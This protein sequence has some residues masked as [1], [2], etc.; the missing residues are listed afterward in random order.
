[1]QHRNFC[2]TSSTRSVHRGT[3]VTVQLSLAEVQVAVADYLRKRG[4]IVDDADQVQ[5]LIVSAVGTRMSITGATPVVEV[6]NVK[7][8]EGPYR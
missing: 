1:M 8:P 7:L 5:L 3:E 6:V 2:A 4:A